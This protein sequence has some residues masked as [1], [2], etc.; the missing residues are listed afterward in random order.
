MII[1]FNDT[2]LE[3]EFIEYDRD[4]FKAAVRQFISYSSLISNKRKE[5]SAKIYFKADISIREFFNSIEDTDL[6]NLL[7]QHFSVLN[8]KYW[9][10]NPVQSNQFNYYFF[11]TL[12]TPPASID[13]ENK[14]LAEAAEVKRLGDKNLLALNLPNLKF[15][16]T[17]HILIN[18][19]AKGNPNDV[20]HIDIECA[21]CSD[22]IEV[23]INRL[24]NN[25]Y[26]YL[27]HLRPPRDMET[28]FSNHIKFTQAAIAAR[29]HGRHVFNDARGNF[30]YVDNLHIGN[31]AHLEVF[32]QNGLHIGEANLDGEIDTSRR[33]PNKTLDI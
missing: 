28:C 14:T 7:L 24:C 2:F 18:V 17:H 26:K 9:N 1:Y 10:N 25:E 22:S 5:L 30:W 8:V 11:D 33:D 6:Y 13:V 31:A 27:D 21:D 16:R 15:N 19:I 29:P 32:D 20:S 3:E 23:W 4:K 12:Q